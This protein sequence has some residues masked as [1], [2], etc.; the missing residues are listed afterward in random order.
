MPRYKIDGSQ[1]SHTWTRSVPRS[2]I[3]IDNRFVI[4]DRPFTADQIVEILDPY[5]SRSR[6]TRIADVVESRT[7][8]VAT[9][10][11]GLVNLGNVSAVMRTAEAFGFQ[12]FHV[13]GR[14]QSFKGSPRTTQGAEKWLDVALWDTPPACAEYL[15]QRGYQLVV[16]VL[17]RD[18]TSIE[19]VD[20]T[21]RTALVFG[22]EAEGVSSAMRE[23]AD[24]MCTIPTPGFVESFNISVAAAVCLYHAYRV[25]LE[26]LGT[27]GD[28]SA[29][30]KAVLTASFYIRAIQHAE[31]LLANA[32][33]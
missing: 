26:T 12:R 32:Q 24:L 16:T 30:K 22:N 15:K 21:R 19:D 14:D 8:S 11:E 4:G 7:H 3:P 18:A 33:S 1:M 25:R 17:D 27:S 23:A 6:R 29:E 9:V 5:L 20:F 31:R 28:L 10:V 13:I 2:A